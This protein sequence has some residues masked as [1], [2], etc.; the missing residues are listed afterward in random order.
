MN[1]IAHQRMVQEALKKKFGSHEV[2]LNKRPPRYPEQAEREFKRITNSYMRLLNKLLKEHLPEIKNAADAE[3][4]RRHDDTTDLLAVATKVFEKIANELQ[5]DMEA[6]GL[7]HRVEDMAKLTRKLSIN[8]WKKAVESTL[9]I[10]LA[11]DYYTGELFRKL[12]KEWIDSNVD[13]IKTIP[14]DS[15]SKMR[16]LVLEGYRNGK[17]TTKIVKEIQEVYGMTRRHAQLIARDQIAKLN[18]QIARLQQ[19]DAGVS[20]Y[21]WSTSGDSRVRQGHK[22]L[23]GKRFKWSD[24][25]IVDAKTGRRCHPGEDYQCRCVA[26]AVFDYETIDLPISE[27][28]GG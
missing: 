18:G 22:A 20:E 2:L 25:P 6:F 13:L 11:D 23:D 28:G 26:L 4:N 3:K 7:E 27:N 5:R 14:N 21:I 12:M 8:E 16:E 15:L 24:P 10:R 9:G 1:D 19:E 17:P